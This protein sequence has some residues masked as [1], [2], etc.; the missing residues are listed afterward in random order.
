V[1]K[2]LLRTKGYLVEVVNNG[3]EAL[4]ALEKR[5]YDVV[6][7]DVQMPEMDGLEATAAIRGNEKISGAHL[8][9]IA[10]TAYA[11]PEDRERCMNAGMDD[12]LS[13]PIL[14]QALFDTIERITGPATS[15]VETKDATQAPAAASP[16]ISALARSLTSLEAIESAIAGVDLKAIR[17]HANAMKG[18]VTS[19]IAKSAFE[20]ASALASTTQED[21]LPRAADA[22]RC[23]H[24][25]LVSLTSR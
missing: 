14:S 8:P 15:P 18:S 10:V 19:L 1:L 6:L 17:A 21:E 11:M 3:R 16:E 13:K 25:A 20:A 12:Y 4:A 22:A 24:D 7:M 23:L 2:G 5:S 9:V